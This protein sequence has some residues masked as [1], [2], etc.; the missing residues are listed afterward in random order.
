MKFNISL[1]NHG[2]QSRETLLDMAL[3]IHLTLQE[4][5]HDSTITLGLMGSPV[6]NLVFEAFEREL[7]QALKGYTYGI[8]CTEMLDEDGC[9]NNRRDPHIVN[10]SGWLA[11]ALFEAKF[12]WLLANKTVPSWGGQLPERTAVLQPMGYVPQL[13]QPLRDPGPLY[14]FFFFGSPSEDRAR[15]ANELG[16]EAR[17]VYGIPRQVRD[18]IMRSSKWTLGLR[19]SSDISMHSPSRISAAIHARCPIIMEHDVRL[20]ND[21]MSLAAQAG[22]GTTVVMNKATLHYFDADH[23]PKKVAEEQL[24]ALMRVPFRPVLEAALDLSLAAVSQVA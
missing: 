10:R 15:L 4:M 8:I 21:E 3:P 19:P 7:V 2:Q 23:D 6:I 5:G 17:F 12:A 13:V 1:F 22:I 11:A 24:A 9:L 20:R 18:N 16:S 14:K